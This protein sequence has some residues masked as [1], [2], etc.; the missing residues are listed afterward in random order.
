MGVNRYSLVPEA[1]IS[2]ELATSINQDQLPLVSNLI[3]RSVVNYQR[4]GAWKMSLG[5]GARG[6][7]YYLPR[8][9]DRHI[10]WSL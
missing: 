7:G 1:Q 4:I 5:D 8:G 9:N 10:G 6:L 3:V 2:L